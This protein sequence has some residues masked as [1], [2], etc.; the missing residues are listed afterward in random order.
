MRQLHHAV[1]L[2]QGASCLLPAS[3]GRALHAHLLLC[4]RLLC[5]LPGSE[6]K[7]L[8]WQVEAGGVHIGTAVNLNEVR[9]LCLE[10]CR[11]QKQHSMSALAVLA[12]QLDHWSGNQVGPCPRLIWL[13]AWGGDHLFMQ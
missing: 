2:S 1:A 9:A 5:H 4:R 12:R 3:D 7:T 11:T 6:L 10:L 13:A 8:S